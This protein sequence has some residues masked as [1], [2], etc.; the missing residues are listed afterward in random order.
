MTMNFSDFEEAGNTGG[1]IKS[2][3]N[4][5][6]VALTVGFWNIV[7]AVNLAVPVAAFKVAIAQDAEFDRDRQLWVWS[8]DFFHDSKRHTAELTGALITNGVEWNMTISQENGF[9]N[10]PWYTGQMSADGS[11]GYWILQHNGT[12]LNDYLRIDWEKENDEVGEIKYELIDESSDDFG[13]Y[14]EYGRV[15]TDDF[16]TYYNI[17]LTSEDRLVEI[18]WNR[19]KGDGRIRVT[20]G[21]VQGDYLCWD[22]S[23]NNADCM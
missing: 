3:S 17:R 11:S 19:D 8:F 1:R 18:E 22:E 2:Q 10:V 14:I 21:T 6:G 23:F 5:N 13:S 9:Q 12:D 16:D 20:E 15:D 4:R 7:L